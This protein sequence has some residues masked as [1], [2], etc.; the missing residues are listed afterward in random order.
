MV[1]VL[2]GDEVTVKLQQMAARVGETP[3]ALAERA[4]RAF[5]H[6]AAREAMR[7]EMQAYHAR[8]AELLRQ[9]AGRYIAMYQGEVVDDDDNQL[10]L[11]ARVEQGYPDLPVLITPVLAEP[12]ETYTVLSPRWESNL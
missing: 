10:A 12:E 6:N 4:V 5:L 7:R 11:L 9:Y 8:H 2:L 3:V 1:E